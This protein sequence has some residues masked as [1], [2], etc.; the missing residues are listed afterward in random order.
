VQQCEARPDRDEALRVF[1]ARLLAIYGADKKQLKR[2]RTD[3]P[4]LA[5]DLVRP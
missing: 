1:G 4:A 2:L 3:Y 5:P